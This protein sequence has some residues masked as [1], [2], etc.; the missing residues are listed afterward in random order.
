MKTEKKTVQDL[1]TERGGL[2]NKR[3]GL[4]VKMN[5]IIDKASAEKRDFTPEEEAKY[6]SLEREFE[7]A[8]RDIAMNNDLLFASKN[9]FVENKSKNA[10]LREFLQEVKSKRSSSECILQRE[11]TGLDTAAIVGGGMIP[12]TIKDVL[13]PL[14]MGLIFDK[15]GIPVQTGV[16][17]DIQWP[18]LGSV[19]A[20]IKGETEALTDQDIDLSKI[21]AKHVRLG[22]SIKISNQAIND[23]YTDLVSLVQS[24]IR[25]GLNRTLNRVI[26]SHQNFTSDLHGPF[27]N[28]KAS[29]TFAGATP[30]YKELLEMKGKIASTGVEMIGFCYIMSEAMKAALEATPV[31]A[32]SGRMIIENGAIAGYPVFCTE[33]INYGSGKEK[34]D[35]EYV[36]A[37]CFGYLPTNQHGEVRMIFDPYTQAKNDVIVITMNADWSITTL[38]KEAFALYKTTGV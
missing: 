25:A 10:M 16:T 9:G 24:Q 18:V 14:E 3:E 20:E 7:Q 35:V 28:A 4:S 12:L 27:A 33:Y 38:R 8:S 32:G 13:P 15:V 29:G 11:F 19:E 2:I 26:F 30:T 6:K 34:A 21:N 1:I 5:E 37:G 31:D 17:G 23:S 36:A 22:I